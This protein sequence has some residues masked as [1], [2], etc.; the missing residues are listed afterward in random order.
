[1]FSGRAVGLVDIGE[2]LG[3]VLGDDALGDALGVGVC[4]SE[5]VSDGV[6]GVGEGDGVGLVGGVDDSVSV[7]VGS[8]VSGGSGDSVDGGGG[9]SLVAGGMVLSHS[10]VSDSFSHSSSVAVPPASGRSRTTELS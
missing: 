9:G 8:S 7:G 4:D 2:S 1:M 5:G 3:A 6:V 10:P